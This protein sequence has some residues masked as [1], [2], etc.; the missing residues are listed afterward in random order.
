MATERGIA[1]QQKSEPARRR[2]D[3]EPQTEGRNAQSEPAVEAFRQARHAPRALTPTAIQALQRTTGNAAVN[4]L[5]RQHG[6]Q[7]GTHADAGVRQSG[8]TARVQGPQSETVDNEQDARAEGVVRVAP[9]PVA[10]STDGAAGRPDAAGQVQRRIHLVGRQEEYPT[11]FVEEI[12]QKMLLRKEMFRTL[13]PDEEGFAT[14]FA[15]LEYLFRTNML[16]KQMIASEVDFGTLDLN[17]DQHLTLLYYQFKRMIGAAGPE[18]TAD[19]AKERETAKEKAAAW[20]TAK[21]ASPAADR[22]YKTAFLGAG[23]SVAYYIASLGKSYDHSTSIVI[24]T[25]QPWAGERGGGVVGHPM[26]MITPMRHYVGDTEQDD[27][28][29]RRSDF[30]DLIA[31]VIDQS[32][33]ATDTRKISGVAKVKDFYKISFEGDAAGTTA[34]Y[35]KEVIAGMGAGK[36]AVPRGVQQGDVATGKGD[37]KKDGKRIMNMDIFTNVAEFLEKDRDGNIVVNETGQSDKQAITLILSGPNAGLDVAFDAVNRG[38]KVHWI[39]GETGP[40]FL[41]GFPNYAAYLPYLK[42][43]KAKGQSTTMI[44]GTPVDINSKIAEL[45]DPKLG[46]ENLYKNQYEDIFARNIADTFK[47][48]QFEGVHFGYAEGASVS[49]K[50]VTVPIK[51]MDAVSGDVFVYAQGQDA[52][53]YNLLDKAI[54][55]SLVPDYDKNMH[56]KRP[57]SNLPPTT[58]GLTT[59]AGDDGTSLK[60]IGATAFRAAAGIGHSAIFPALEGYR[61]GLMDTAIA[62]MQ[63]SGTGGGDDFMSAV[64]GLSDQMLKLNAAYGELMLAVLDKEGLEQPG[65]GTPEAIAAVRQKIKSLGDVEK[66]ATEGFAERAKAIKRLN[67]SE[68]QAGALREYEG[69]LKSANTVLAAASSMRDV[70]DSLPENV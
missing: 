30:T 70:I 68:A 20:Q 26:H 4:Q 44:L 41:P 9:A 5:L 67:P 19:A 17:S 16:L 54:Q 1:G 34:I 69:V 65:G 8:S 12:Q 37:I 11:I 58:L 14:V 36:H 59:K 6:A 43:L 13:D 62:W 22:T 39:V 31:Q 60:L 21:A 61:I 2:P 45:E 48:A 50:G 46:I 7:P 18:V 15:K 32:G 33:A 63:A 64:G 38:Y 35:A 25:V 24:G 66:K 56:F 57:D 40:L 51:G 3:A 52:A 53:A 10:R 42:Y 29:A 49:A 27:V 28:W 55:D 23:A 47:E